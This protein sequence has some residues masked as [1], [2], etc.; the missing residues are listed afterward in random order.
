MNAPE[1][2]PETAPAPPPEEHAKPCDIQALVPLMEMRNRIGYVYGSEDA[3]MLLYSIVRREQ[4]KN[5]V[6]LG[7]GL[8]VCAAWMAQAMK[9]LGT[10]GRVW[11]LDDGSHWEDLAKLKLFLGQLVEV[12][13]FDRIN[14]RDLDYPTY[15]QRLIEVTGLSNHL[16]FIHDRL[17]LS[18]EDAFYARKYGFLTKPIDTLFIDINRTP[19]VIVD[20]LFMFLPHLNESASIFVDSAS[21]SLASYLFLEK[22]IDQLNHSKVPRR[23]LAGQNKDRRRML[24]ELVS[25]RRFTLMHLVERLKREQNS[26]A[27]I[28]VE[29]NDYVPHPKT[30][31]KWV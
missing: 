6:E 28:R 17:E 8:G 11:T 1:T 19:D 15:M 12:P 14:L 5:L 22:L 25:Q 27:W 23:F 7:A 10:G 26:M 16:S 31:M 18:S 20:T 9:E 29:P 21:S 30:M 3:A 2:A 13:P 4:P 24:I